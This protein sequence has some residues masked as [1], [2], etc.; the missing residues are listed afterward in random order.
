MRI[1]QQVQTPAE[2]RHQLFI[3]LSAWPISSIY[4]SF[5]DRSRT[6]SLPTMHTP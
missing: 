1:W 2:M 3:L 5:D 6:L 4:G